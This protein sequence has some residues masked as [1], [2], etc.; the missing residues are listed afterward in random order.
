MQCLR[1]S[2]FILLF[3]TIGLYDVLSA[4]CQLAH[5]P[6]V[7]LLS[8]WQTADNTGYRYDRKSLKLFILDHWQL[9]GCYVTTISRFQRRIFVRLSVMRPVS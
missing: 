7:L 5:N 2:F 3:A 4:H 9:D 1:C 6:V 8:L